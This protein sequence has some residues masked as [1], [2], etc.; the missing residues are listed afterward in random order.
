MRLDRIP[1]CSGARFRAIAWAFA[2]V[3]ILLMVQPSIG[4]A[5]TVLSERTQV[6]G[7]PQMQG[8]T[9]ADAQTRESTTYLQGKKIRTETEGRI[10]VLDFDKAML[11]TI[12][13]SAKTYSEMSL[14]ALKEAQK[15][16]MEWIR[17]L[18]AQVEEKMKTMPPESRE[19]MRK[20]LDSLPEAMFGGEETA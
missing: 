12:D 2:A 18:R 6:V 4:S 1:C 14:E 17:T 8:P 13:P 5:G 10:W 15:Q 20:K 3:L 7:G 16:A 11:I 19:A 9:A